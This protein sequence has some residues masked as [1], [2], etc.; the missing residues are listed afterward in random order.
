M[1]RF[2]QSLKFATVLTL[3]I[4]SSSCIKDTLSPKSSVPVTAATGGGI[5]DLGEISAGVHHYSI[6]LSAVQV[7]MTN[8]SPDQ[9]ESS[10]A[11]IDLY[12]DTDGI[13]NDGTYHFSDSGNISPFTFKSG[14]LY[15]TPQDN[16]NYNA[17]SVS[18]GTI[19]V[20]RNGST[21]YLITI[22]GVASS[23][24]PFT[25]TFSGTLSYQDAVAQN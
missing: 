25:G 3:A 13:I 11:V 9:T 8:I 4:I 16:N 6:S 5:T 18:D 7:A 21:S 14:A 15:L 10:T 12:T 20:Q 19:S 22:T 2:N 17:L 23:G 24:E 1:R